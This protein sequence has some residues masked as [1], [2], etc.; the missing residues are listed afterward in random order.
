[1]AVVGAGPAGLYAVQSLLASAPGIGV[2]VFDRLPTP[3]GLVRYGVAPDN[4][5]IKSVTR[6]LRAAF[7]HGNQ[8]RFLGNVRFGTDIKRA[9]LLEHYDA[10]VYATGAQ[11]ER[12]LGIPGEDLP[13][14][15][16]AKDFVDW[17]SGHPDA[18]DRDFLLNATQVAVVGAGNVALDVAR[19]LVR[20][21]GEIAS[22]D[23]PDRVLD[24]FRKSRVS[25]VHLIA[26]RGPVQAKF[27]PEELRAMNDLADAEVVVRP[28]DLV[29][30]KEDEIRI[31]S[32]RNLRT[33][34]SMLR[35]WAE[36]QLRGKARRIHIRFL[37]SPVRILGEDTVEGVLLE[38]NALLAD[39]RV[40]GTGS[41]ETLA[42]GM[43]FRSV[44]YQ[45]LPLPDVPFDEAGSII[46]HSEGRVLNENGRLT[47]GEYVTGWAK[48]GPC[49]VIG[50]NKSDSAETVC[51]LLADL[52]G[53]DSYNDTE[54]GRVLALLDNRGV[55]YTNWVNWLRLDDH[56]IQLGRRQGRP[57]VKIPVLRAMLDLSRG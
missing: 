48:R 51:N 40:R 18:A 32:N 20:S 10:V 30:T 11:G 49:G 3:Y 53:R 12:R 24:A 22:T 9:D 41:F 8:V 15:C 43:I 5:K 13:G 46:P 56:E 54:P 50:T 36:R 34:V 57:R 35:E 55:D 14:S 45:A 29:L 37:Q 33:N 26:R 44:G 19:M 28:E 31:A 1:M 21:P 47:E 16:G 23:V 7:D 4:Q 25:D 6:V 42:L 27:T 2:D 17:Y 52:A 38:R 39:G